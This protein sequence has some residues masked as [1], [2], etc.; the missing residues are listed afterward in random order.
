MIG[1]DFERVVVDQD[2][3]RRRLHALPE[4]AEIDGNSEIDKQAN[5]KVARNFAQHLRRTAPQ[6]SAWLCPL[7]SL[8]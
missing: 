6:G 2:D 8:A 1:N 3:K 5:E 4:M 7:R